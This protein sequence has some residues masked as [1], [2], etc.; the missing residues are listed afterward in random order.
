[1][2]FL[3]LDIQE[4]FFEALRLLVAAVIAVVGWFVSGPIIQ[5]LWYLAFRKAAPE[6][7]AGW[8]RL[9]VAI[10]VGV[11]AWLY[12]P[13]G[14]GWGGGGSGGGQGPGVGPFKGQGTDVSTQSGKGTGAGP[15]TGTG[16]DKSTAGKNV[17]TI[18][19]LG[20][21]AVK[22]GRFYVVQKKQP[23]VDWGAL[24]QYLG[25]TEGSW[26]EIRIL[27]SG[28]SIFEDDI[29]VR[30]VR[31]WATEHGIKRSVTR[32]ADPK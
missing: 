9:A 13:I 25:D 3:G 8:L 5:T 12:L 26:A 19:V 6:W 27:L 20:G 17:L 10:L 18:E 22:E 11:L 7:V 30:R 24:K 29:V 15:G 23:P 31:D 14:S 1:M 21:A 32:I 16:T 2:A 4:L 28:D